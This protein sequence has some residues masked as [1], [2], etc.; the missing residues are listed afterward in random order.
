MKNFE[1]IYEIDKEDG[2]YWGF[3][4]W[5]DFFARRLKPGAR[6]VPEDADLYTV[7]AACEATPYQESAVQFAAHAQQ[8]AHALPSHSWVALFT[9]I[10]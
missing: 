3:A 4:S 1:E 2:K 10:S 7:V 5:N 8:R 9:R 6:P